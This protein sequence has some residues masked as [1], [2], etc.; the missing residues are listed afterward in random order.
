M[1]NKKPQIEQKLSFLYERLQEL[2]EN[3]PTESQLSFLMNEIDYYRTELLKIQVKEY[4]E[5]I[6]N[7]NN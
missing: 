1:T 3:S 4:Y 6:E 7:E 5:I 2:E